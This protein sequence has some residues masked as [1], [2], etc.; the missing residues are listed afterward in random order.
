MDPRPP[1]RPWAP[2]RLP[3][4]ALT[5]REAGAWDRRAIDRSG[6]PERVLMENAGRAAA[7]ILDRSYPEGPVVGLV[8]AGNNGGDALVALRVLAAWGREVRAVL[9]ADRPT[10]DPLL[11]G[12]PIPVVVEDGWTA[13]DWAGVLSEA[14]VVVDGVLGTGVRGAPRERQAGAIRA[15]NASAASVLAMDVPSGIDP[16]GGSVPGD[17]VRA[18]VTVAFGAPKVGALVHPARAAVGRLV[19]VEIGFPPLESGEARAFV[20]T[21][22]WARDQLPR[23]SSDTH[24]NAVGRVLVVGGASGMAGAALLAARGALRAGAGIVRVCTVPENREIVQRGVP[25][26]IYVDGTD[27]AAVRDGLA[28]TD[29][30]VVGPGLGQG[31]VAL[32]LLE[33]VL[34]GEPRPVL[35]DADAL[36]LAAAGAVDLAAVGRTRPVLLTPHPGEMGRLS[37]RRRSASDGRCRALPRRRAATGAAAVERFDRRGPVQGRALCPSSAS[38]DGEL[39]IDTQGSSDLAAAGMGDTLAG[40]CGT[41]MAQGLVSA[42]AGAVGL[43][44]T[45]R[46]AR[47]ADK[48][49][50][51]T[52]SD[53]LE[54]LPDVLS[55]P[56]GPTDALGLPFVVLDIDPAA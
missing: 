49:A 17:A 14:S 10:D 48:G 22:P 29:A 3:V 47:L 34:G 2:H 9:V 15:V 11:H 27:A 21:P 1:L 33:R 51:L 31:D 4:P 16:D 44:L 30:V 43:Y 42:T 32:R 54:R 41:L 46:A 53:V 39:L 50:A 13:E 8:G 26:A 37:R 52:P 24:K 40:V 25:E 18:D 5:G 6:V 36:N 45:G 56:G 35:L 7:V 38:P 28:A 19:V 23:R 20:S 12:W 55:E